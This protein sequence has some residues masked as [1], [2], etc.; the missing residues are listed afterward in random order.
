MIWSRSYRKSPK[1]RFPGASFRRTGEQEQVS[2]QVPDDEILGAPRLPLERLVERDARS[3]KFRVELLDLRGCRNGDGGGEKVLA[4]PQL[5]V[6]DGTDHAFK[7]ESPGGSL[8]SSG[9]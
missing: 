7:I 6:D 8:P 1:M 9:A 4:L 3:L 5:G 2:V